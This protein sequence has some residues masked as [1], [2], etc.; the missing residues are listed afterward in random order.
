MR[1]L[2]GTTRREE[3]GI[4][5]YDLASLCGA[6]VAG[7]R[8]YRSDLLLTLPFF[9]MLRTSCSQVNRS[10]DISRVGLEYIDPAA[11]P[12]TF[13]SLPSK[14]SRSS[15]LVRYVAAFPYVLRSHLESADDSTLEIRIGHLISGNELTHLMSSSNRPN[16][17]LQLV[18]S[19]AGE[20][21][22]MEHHAR[23]KLDGGITA[24]LDAFG[25]LEKILRTPI[26][27]GYT[28]HTSRVCLL[29]CFAMPWVLYGDMGAVASTVASGLIT[30]VLLGIE[31]IGVQVCANDK[32]F[33]SVQRPGIL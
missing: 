16:A 24:L 8:K 6:L 33:R 29:W 23:V 12:T 14:E 26:P 17:M 7:I 32:R 15:Q 22:P 28:R 13:S 2:L 19:V 30:F 25:S 3:H 21:C 27:L 31:D 18:T 11:P 20:S 9:L 1:P 5:L 4:L 10:V